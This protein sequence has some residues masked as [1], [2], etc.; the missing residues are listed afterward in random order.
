ML[1]NCN[2]R[3][4]F[5]TMYCPNCGTEAVPEAVFCNKCGCNLKERAQP[6]PAPASVPY[7]LPLKNS[8]LAAVLS[9]L[10]TGLGQIYA[11]KISR[12][13]IFILVAVGVAMVTTILLFAG[14]VTDSEGVVQSFDSLYLAAIVGILIAY[15]AFYIWQIYD[16]YILTNKYNDALKQTGQEPW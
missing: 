14:L 10:F 1:Y 7:A 4:P 15:L 13:I 3:Y 8:G 6:A 12:G 16:A 2:K 9:F 11:G 5:D